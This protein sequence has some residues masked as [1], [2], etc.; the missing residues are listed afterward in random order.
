LGR[1]SRGVKVAR[2]KRRVS[3]TTNVS[4]RAARIDLAGQVENDGERVG[5]IEVGIHSF[6]ETRDGLLV[7]VA[8]QRE[9]LRADSTPQA[10]E[11]RTRIFDLAHPRWLALDRLGGEGQRRAV[12]RPDQVEADLDWLVARQDGRKGEE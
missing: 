9:W 3:S 4:Q 12:V 8:L 7:K 5:G 11:R 1:L 10:A 6:L 2:R